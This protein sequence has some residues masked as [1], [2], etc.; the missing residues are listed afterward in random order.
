M[1]KTLNNMGIEGKYGNVIKAT[2]DKPSAN[3][4]LDS[5]TLKA[6]P[7]KSGARQ[8]CPLS[9]LIFNTVLEVL[10]G[11]TRREKEI[12]SIQIIW[13]EEVQVSLFAGDVILY[14]E[15]PKD[16][17]TSPFEIINKYSKVTGHKINV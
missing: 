13:K 12:K 4:T 9:P 16:S 1:I 2:Y 17:S 10:A 7:S 14:I 5:E 15:N 8:G 11:V 6:F 3:I